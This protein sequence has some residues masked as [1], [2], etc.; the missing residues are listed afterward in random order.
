M[1]DDLKA[2]V[3]LLDK[4][5]QRV[6]G[7]D[8]SIWTRLMVKRLLNPLHIHISRWCRPVAA[9]FAGSRTSITVVP[10]NFV[11]QSLHG[12]AT[13]YWQKM[14]LTVAFKV[15]ALDATDK[16]QKNF[17]NYVVLVHTSLNLGRQVLPHEFKQPLPKS[18]VQHSPRFRLVCLDSIN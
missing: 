9:T 11:A 15:I 8:N 1:H 12:K 5:T 18:S 4:G 17:L 3:K 13:N 14:F 6:M 2:R 16:A 7:I 10:A